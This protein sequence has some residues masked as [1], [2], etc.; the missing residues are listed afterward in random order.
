MSVKGE[1]YMLASAQSNDRTG[2]RQLGG[3]DGKS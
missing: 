1:I 3:Q 2:E